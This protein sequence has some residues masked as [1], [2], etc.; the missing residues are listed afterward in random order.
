MPFFQFAFAP[1]PFSLC[2]VIRF[3]IVKN[4]SITF[5]IVN[6]DFQSQQT[7]KLALSLSFGFISDNHFF[8]HE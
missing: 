3:W 7:Y 5:E 1:L 4:S 8:V 2:Q 6:D